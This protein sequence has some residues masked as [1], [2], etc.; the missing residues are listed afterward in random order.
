MEPNGA[1]CLA[2]IDRY[3]PVLTGCLGPTDRCP[4]WRQWHA[5]VSIHAPPTRA[6]HRSSMARCSLP[7][8]IAHIGRSVH[9]L[10]VRVTG[11]LGLLKRAGYLACCPIQDY[12]VPCWST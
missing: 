10:V 9:F 7:E 8:V 4:P 2:G 12:G 3:R 5:G 1:A 11:F 6:R